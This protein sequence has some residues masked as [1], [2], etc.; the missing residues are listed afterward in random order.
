MIT[1]PLYAYL[2]IVTLATFGVI[3]IF[4]ALSRV[5]ENRKKEKLLLF[6]K[7]LLLDRVYNLENSAKSKAL[8]YKEDY[9]SFKR[10][11]TNINMDIRVLQE[12][13]ISI[14]NILKKKDLDMLY[15]KKKD[16]YMLYRCPICQPEDK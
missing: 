13:V 11:T 16:L 4:A 7:K 6:E 8:G 14:K 2:T 15:R 5:L 9:N 1:I 10:A 3:F 12:Q